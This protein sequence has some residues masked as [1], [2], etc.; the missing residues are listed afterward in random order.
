MESLLD[1][2][3]FGEPVDIGFIGDSF[4]FGWGVEAGERYSDIVRDA[5]PD[6]L[7]L[8]YSYPN[9]HAPAYYL[10]FLQNHPERISNR[11]KPYSL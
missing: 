6:Q 8:S 10:S 7:V 3:Y 5:F 4:T 11:Y 1:Q 9:G 2:D